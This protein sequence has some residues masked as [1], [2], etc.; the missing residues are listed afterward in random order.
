[1]LE[2][3]GDEIPADGDEKGKQVDERFGTRPGFGQRKKRQN[4][5]KPCC[6][7]GEKQV[8]VPVV[9]FVGEKEVYEYREQKA[10]QGE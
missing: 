5:E 8:H 9:R 3:D 4:R 2:G 6:K 1:M 10:G 7:P